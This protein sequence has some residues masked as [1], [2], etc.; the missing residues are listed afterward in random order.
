MSRQYGTVNLLFLLFVYSRLLT[1]CPLHPHIFHPISSAPCC[2]PHVVYLT[3]TDVDDPRNSF[4]GRYRTVSGTY[5]NISSSVLS[6]I[7]GMVS[8]TRP[9]FC[10]SY[11]YT[12]VVLLV[13]AFLS[14]YS[15]ILKGTVPRLSI[16]ACTL[17]HAWCAS[18]PVG[19]HMTSPVERSLRKS[20]GLTNWL[21]PHL[22]S[23]RSGFHSSH[24]AVLLS[25]IPH[26]FSMLL[27]SF[28][29]VL[30]FSSPSH[31]GIVWS[32]LFLHLSILLTLAS[33][34]P[35]C[36]RI[37]HFFSC[38][39]PSVLLLLASLFP[40]DI[41]RRTCSYPDRFHIQF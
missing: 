4:S 11:I 14:P 21:E 7:P 17:M 34:I 9:S 2:L 1:P 29:L 28:L 10:L 36:S 16:L 30:V 23:L 31:S 12:Y 15:S 18:C 13:L 26:S 25:H 37:F 24:L 38:P 27:P 41:V 6:T 32:F 8:C 40:S 3:G 22:F 19:C 33:L 5:F 39:N 20:G 35:S